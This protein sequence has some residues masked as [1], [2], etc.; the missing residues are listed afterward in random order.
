[1]SEIKCQQTEPVVRPRVLSC[2]FCYVGFNAVWEV[3]EHLESSSCQK[4]PDL[5]RSSMYRRQCQQ[6]PNGIMTVHNSAGDVGSLTTETRLYHCPNNAGGCNGKFMSSFAQLLAHLE[7]ESCGFV[8]RE[9]LW[10]DISECKDLWE[11]IDDL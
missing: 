2:P 4:R 6:D 8:K 7:G 1:L 3:A 9:D 10:K 5:N 11:D